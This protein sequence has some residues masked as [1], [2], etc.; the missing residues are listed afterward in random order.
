M[1]NFNFNKIILGGRLTAN[2]EL[3]QTLQ[4]VAVTTF[5]IAVNRAYQKGNDQQTDFINCTAW[6]GAAEFITKYF[7]KGSCICVVGELNNRSW[8]DRDGNKRISTEVVVSEANFVD[9]KNDNIQ[10]SA[11]AYSTPAPTPMVPEETPR[12]EELGDDEDLPF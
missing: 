11:P 6:R 1:A 9:G 8:T 5:G 2:P 10:P 3:K 12:F 7:Q 4:G